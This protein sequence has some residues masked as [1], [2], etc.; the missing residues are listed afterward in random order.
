MIKWYIYFILIICIDTLIDIL[1]RCGLV[2]YY[3]LVNILCVISIMDW[4]TRIANKIIPVCVHFI[5]P[6]DM[7]T[8]VYVKNKY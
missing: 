6:I 3:W 8:Q 2:T 1:L 4:V 7:R 5:T